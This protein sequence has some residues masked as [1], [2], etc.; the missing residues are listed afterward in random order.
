ML[1]HFLREQPQIQ[2]FQ[3]GLCRDA[4]RQLRCIRQIPQCYR[5]VRLVAQV[6]YPQPVFPPGKLFHR[7]VPLPDLGF[8]LLYQ[9]FGGVLCNDFASLHHGIFGRNV[10]HIRNDMR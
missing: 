9:P 3:P 2:I 8:D 4:V 6:H 10:F 7:D 5:S 1:P